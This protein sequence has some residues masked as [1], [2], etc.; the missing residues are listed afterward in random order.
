MRKFDRTLELA[1]FTATAG[2]CSRAR[3]QQ[4]KLLLQRERGLNRNT[5]IRYVQVWELKLYFY[6]SA[7]GLKKKQNK[8]KHLCA[9]SICCPAYIHMEM[10][11]MA[12]LKR[13]NDACIILVRIIHQI[14]TALYSSDFFSRT[15]HGNMET[16]LNYQV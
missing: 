8:T 16:T 5:C 10:T 15:L 6:P 7:G 12:A 14:L 9:W 4:R 3:Q 2:G 1:C 11:S 13:E